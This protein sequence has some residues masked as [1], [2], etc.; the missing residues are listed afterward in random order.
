M[1]K[2]GEIGPERTRSVQKAQHV[3]QRHEEDQFAIELP[4]DGLL[5]VWRVELVARDGAGAGPAAH[6][7]LLVRLPHGSAAS[8]QRI[9]RRELEGLDAAN[10]GAQV[11]VVVVVDIRVEVELLACL[12]KRRRRRPG[13]GAQ[14]LRHRWKTLF[15]H[16]AES[17]G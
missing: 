13:V 1:E 11:V 3:E 12:R 9:P 10:L 17:C 16:S 5:L 15:S 4:P 2:A 6:A 14:P 8:A 7:R